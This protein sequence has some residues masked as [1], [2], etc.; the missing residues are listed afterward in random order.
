MQVSPSNRGHIDPKTHHTQTVA[1]VHPAPPQTK[2]QFVQTSSPKPSQQPEDKVTHQHPGPV[3]RSDG[4][5]SGSFPTQSVKTHHFM[6]QSDINKLL[7]KTT[8]SKEPTE[9]N[10]PSKSTVLS[11]VIMFLMK[12]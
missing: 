9:T 7:K 5:V 2:N 1:E 8:V 12:F 11:E 3:R 4:T 6:K 10:L